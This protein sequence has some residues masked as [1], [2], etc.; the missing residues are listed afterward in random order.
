MSHSWELKK[1]DHS[2]SETT[3]LLGLRLCL[4]GILMRALCSLECS[5][6]SPSVPITAVVTRK[7]SLENWMSCQSILDH[8]KYHIY[9]IRFSQCHKKYRYLHYIYI[10][11]YIYTREQKYHKTS[12]QPLVYLTI[13]ICIYFHIYRVTQKKL[14]TLGKPKV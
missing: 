3:Y 7:L 13:S 14:G 6:V 11:I 1:L 4:Q 9:I 8:S 5:I 10:H 12:H 2:Y